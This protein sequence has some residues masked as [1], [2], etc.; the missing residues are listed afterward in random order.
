MCTDVCP[1]LSSEDTTGA[2]AALT[3]AEVT[4]KTDTRY[5]GTSATLNTLVFTNDSSS[6]YSTFVDC[7]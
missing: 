2:Y 4:A 6:G 7:F 3:S 5:V 1:C